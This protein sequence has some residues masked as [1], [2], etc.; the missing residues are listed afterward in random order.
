MN[1][2]FLSVKWVIDEG[3]EIRLEEDRRWE[4]GVIYTYFN[5]CARCYFKK[6]SANK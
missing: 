6:R 4:E 2:C 3:R 1:K 5:N